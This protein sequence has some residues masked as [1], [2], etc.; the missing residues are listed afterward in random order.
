MM[1]LAAFNVENLFDRAK[2]MNLDSWE[3]GRPVLERFDEL[4]RLLGEIEYPAAAKARMAELMI[5]L[6]LERSD[7]GRFVILRRNRGG[8]LKRP[9]D[10]GIEIVADG[11]VDWVGSLELRDEPI[12]ENAM[13]NTARVLVDIEADVL[14]V[15]EAESRPVLAD[16]NRLILPA[17]GGT[18]F[19]HVMVIDGNDER[20]IDVGLMSR[21]GFPI[22]RMR[23]HVDDRLEN[24]EPVFSRDCPEYEVTTPDG[25]RVVVM[26]N[27]FKSKGYG[28]TAS[29]NRKRKAQAGRV[30]EIY[31]E[32]RE[33]GQDMIA[34]VGDLN[35]TP[36]STPLAPLIGE[37]DLRDAF[38]HQDFD[39]GGFP[40][41]YGSSTANNKIDYLLLS[42][43]LFATVERGGVWRKGMWPGVRPRKWEC[44][45][46]I[47]REQEAAS[48]HAAI[49]VDLRV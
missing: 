43:A 10:G 19:R 9:R 11:R 38:T 44:Y 8:L 22:G 36:D 28:S 15:V 25:G 16:F 49:W 29:S 20:G 26:V 1:R 13:R 4:S 14:G 33:A 40:G 46:E 6:G 21:E 34:I 47:T 3:E 2:A 24:G 27:H 18:P 31:R 12:N 48:D 32:L 39:D 41:T 37:T 7:T 30:A 5:E 35:D 42:P 45:E 17:I 23:S